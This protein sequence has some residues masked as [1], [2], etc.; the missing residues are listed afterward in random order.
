MKLIRLSKKINHT[1]GF[2]VTELMIATTVFSIILVLSLTGFL[3]IGQMFYKGVNITNTTNTAKQVITSLKTDISFDSTSAGIVVP[4]GSSS[5]DVLADGKGPFTR[6]WFCAGSNRYTYI[7]GRQVDREAAEV[8]IR[9]TAF[10]NPSGWYEFALL[11]DQVAGTSCPDPF[12]G[13][14]Q[15]QSNTVTE[16][17]GDKMRLSKLEISQLLSPNDKLYTIT[18]KIAYGDDE[19][20]DD[21]GLDSAKCKSGAASSRYCYVTEI[22]TTAREGF[23]P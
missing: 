22:R 17:I 23:Q 14:A 8:Q 1:A 9:S 4:Q 6:Y 19:V 20:L 18:I 21:F 12:I 3:Q 13:V 5:I 2:T 7:L 16:L 15:L 11:K 10:N